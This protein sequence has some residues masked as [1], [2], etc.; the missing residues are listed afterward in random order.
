MLFTRRHFFQIA[1]AATATITLGIPLKAA[2]KPSETRK[3][4]PFKGFLPSHDRSNDFQGPFP[5]NA[6]LSRLRDIQFKYQQQYD[7]ANGQEYSSLG[8]PSIRNAYADAAKPG[9]IHNSKDARAF[10]TDLLAAFD[11][12]AKKG[13]FPPTSDSSFV[14]MMDQLIL[15]IP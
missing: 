7:M 5:E 13:G 9:T 8:L 10:I 6:R 11:E 14:K 2:N 1:S 15:K 4:E 12:H 3:S